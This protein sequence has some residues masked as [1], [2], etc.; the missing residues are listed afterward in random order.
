MDE[1]KEEKE[2]AVRHYYL[3]L[4]KKLNEMTKANV[5]VSV[6]KYDGYLKP[7]EEFF[8]RYMLDWRQPAIWNKFT[9][10]NFKTLETRDLPIP[11]I[12][13]YQRAIGGM[14]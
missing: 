13:S 10:I 8:E 6:N 4:K 11:K 9:A 2:L 12:M 1:E 14:T 7:I 5:A 3:S